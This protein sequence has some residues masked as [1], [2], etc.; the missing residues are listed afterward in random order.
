MGVKKVGGWGEGKARSEV[1]V[2][3]DTKGVR[4]RG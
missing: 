4:A 1:G 2:L 3:Q